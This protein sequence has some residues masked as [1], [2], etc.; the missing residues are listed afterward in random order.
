MVNKGNVN[1][2]GEGKCIGCGMCSVVCPKKIIEIKPN[3][4]GF[5]NPCIEEKECTKCGLC[6]NICFKFKTSNDT[7]LESPFKNKKVISAVVTD[8]S[9]LSKVSSGGV[10][11]E[12]IKHFFIKGYDVCGV[13]FNSD[14]TMCKHIIANSLEDIGKIRNSK[15]IQSYTVD[16]FKSI[17]KT[18]KNLIIGTPCQ[19][20]AWRKYITGKDFEKNFILVDFFCRGVPSNFLWK[21]YISYINRIYDVSEF[22]EVNFR[23]KSLGWHK[24][25]LKIIGN[26]RT[27]EITHDVYTDL[28]YSFFLKNKCFCLSCYECTLRKEEVYSDLR[29][30]DFWGEK[31][32]QNDKG[33]SLVVVMTEIGEQAWN[34]VSKCFEVEECN[35]EEIDKSQRFNKYILPQDYFEILDCFS[36]YENL[37]NIHTK[38]GLDQQGFYKENK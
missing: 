22:N 33:V 12:L 14:Y 25:S 38:Y 2:L 35:S 7:N 16:A 1:S 13:S 34:E 8:E 36:R 17:D 27:K 32:Y 20:Y 28:F 5:F 10:A 4:Y 30:G 18:K 19:I 11:N 6:S 15:Y 21:A 31:Y 24:F 26:Q 37:E 3:N 29:L 23:D 9:E